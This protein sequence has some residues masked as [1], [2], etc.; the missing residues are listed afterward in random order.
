LSLYLSLLDY[1]SLLLYL[2]AT[3]A[4]YAFTSRSF[5]FSNSAIPTLAM[6]KDRKRSPASVHGNDNVRN[7]PPLK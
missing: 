7:P 6:A 1:S 2:F 5:P 3:I 4:C